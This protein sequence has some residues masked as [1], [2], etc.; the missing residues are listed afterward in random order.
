M[1]QFCDNILIKEQDR[2]LV[3][4]NVRLPGP[5]RDVSMGPNRLN[6]FTFL[7]S[8]R[9]FLTFQSGGKIASFDAHGKEICT[10]SSTE[11][12]M[13]EDF[14]G[15]VL[16]A[17]DQETLLCVKK[18]SSSRPLAVIEFRHV[19]TGELLTRV[20]L[21][22]PVNEVTCLCYDEERMILFIGTRDGL[23]HVWET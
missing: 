9:I 7:H 15:I 10:V 4:H 23:I 19:L 22:C 16:V 5:F 14:S 2:D 21:S 3:I 18:D 8:S 17:R 20:P 11:P 12:G 6:A 1:E 13:N